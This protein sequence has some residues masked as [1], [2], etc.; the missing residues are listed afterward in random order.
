MPFFDPE[1]LAD[2]SEGKWHGTSSDITGFNIDSRKIKP[3]EMFVAIR[4][5]RDGHDFLDQAKLNGASSALVE[6]VKLDSDLPQLEVKNTLIS[7]HSIS[8]CHREQFKKAVIG[9]TGSC[10]KTSTKEFLALLLGEKSHRTSGNLNNYLGVPLTLTQLDSERH[11]S[12]VVEVGINQQNEMDQLAQIVSPDLVLITMIG[13]SH[14]EGLGNL[15]TVAKEKAKLFKCEKRPVC[16][17]F[18]SDCLEFKEFSDLKEK[19]KD[20]FILVKGIPKKDFQDERMVHYEIWTETNKIGDSCMLRLWRH[21]SPVLQFEIP[22]MSVGM[23]KNLVLAIL[24][25]L[26]LKVSPAEISE[27]LPQYR[28]SALRAKSYQGRGRTY[29]VDC[30]NANP[31]SMR[32]SLEYFRSTY[33]GNPKLYVLGG[34]EELGASEVELHESVGAALKLEINDLVVLIGRKAAWYASGLLKSGADEEQIVILKDLEAAISLVE[35]FKG[36][37]LLKGSRSNQL[38]NLLPAW[39]VNEVETGVQLEC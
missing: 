27:R 22:L 20:H 37:I 39:A 11:T 2:W 19:S 29:F 16:V 36:V 4:A 17:F 38:E 8:A 7:F 35:D 34:M 12:A 15:E 13:E 32:D 23:Q 14:L 18:H 6:K 5:K 31:S 28:P 3:G 9:I 21:E 30:Y 24:A 33:L 26:K 25:A 1:K 10:G